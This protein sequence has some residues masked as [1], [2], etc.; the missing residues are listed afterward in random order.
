MTKDNPVIPSSP[1]NQAIEVNDEE[2]FIYRDA[3]KGVK[4]IKNIMLI[5]LAPKTP[6]GRSVLVCRAAISWHPCSPGST[7]MGTFN[8]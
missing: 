2:I 6:R 1:A 5:R 3:V 4:S 8:C 7:V